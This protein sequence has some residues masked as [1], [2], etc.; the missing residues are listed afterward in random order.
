[1]K[2]DSTAQKYSINVESP[3]EGWAFCI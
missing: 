3:T 2:C 1:M